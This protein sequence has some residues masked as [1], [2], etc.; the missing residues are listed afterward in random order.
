MLSAKSRF[1]HEICTSSVSSFC[2]LV[3]RQQIRKT[4]P[5]IKSHST[6]VRP[7]QTVTLPEVPSRQKIQRMLCHFECPLKK[8]YDPLTS[9]M[10]TSSPRAPPPPLKLT[11]ATLGTKQAQRKLNHHL[12]RTVSGRQRGFY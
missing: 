6:E 9:H 7:W 11:G 2:H 1:T 3:S 5:L 4:L 10:M 8:A 12:I